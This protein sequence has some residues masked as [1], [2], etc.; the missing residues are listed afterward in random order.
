LS[1]NI[2]AEVSTLQNRIEE[3]L[4][5]NRYVVDAGKQYNRVKPH[6]VPSAALKSLIAMCP[7]GCYG[8][9]DQGKIEIVA[10]AEW[11]AGSA[12][13]FAL[14]PAISNGTIRAAASACCSSSGNDQ[15]LQWNVSAFRD[16][17]STKTSS[18]RSTLPCQPGWS[19][20]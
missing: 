8:M 11:N 2:G 17:P 6:D 4:F 5:Q 1:E 7:A 3:K 13:S 9:T 14:P 16:S 19:C 20:R 10:M 18:R 12:V 15:R